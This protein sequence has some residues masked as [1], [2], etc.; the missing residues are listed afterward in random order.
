MKPRN[1]RSLTLLAV[2][3]V[4]AVIV[5]GLIRSIRGVKPRLIGRGNGRFS[6][7]VTRP[8]KTSMLETASQRIH[9]HRHLRSRRGKRKKADFVEPCPSL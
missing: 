7:D 1:L 4:I 9:S 3:L 6:K 2:L 8:L 5:L